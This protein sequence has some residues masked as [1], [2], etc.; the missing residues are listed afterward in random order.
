MVNA[1]QQVQGG[2][3]N[4]V[5]GIK[6]LARVRG[7]PAVR[8]SPQPWQTTLQQR[9]DRHPISV[10]CLE[11]ELHG[12]LVAAPRATTSGRHVGIGHASVRI[13]EVFLARSLH[14]LLSP[15]RQVFWPRNPL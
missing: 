2:F 7:Q 14:P 8:P 6:T 4:K 3:L 1:L 5:A 11:P 10:T 13:I 12:G 15:D 9:L